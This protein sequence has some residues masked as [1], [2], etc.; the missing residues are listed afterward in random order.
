M[1][2]RTDPQL[3]TQ[4][5]GYVRGLVVVRRAVNIESPIDEVQR[6]LL[7]AQKAIRQRVDLETPAAQPNIAAWRE[8]Y[9]AFGAKPTEFPSSIEALVKR[10]RRGD[11][12]PYINTLAAICNSASLRYLVPIGGH[13]I[14]VMQA[15]GELCLGFA[16]GDE[17][18]IPFGN[19]SIEHPVP[20]EVIFTYN[21]STVLCRR[22]TWRQGELSKLQRTTTAAVI[23]VDGLPPVTRADVEVISNDLATLVGMYCGNAPTEVKMLSEEQIEVEL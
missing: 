21:T 13:A 23:N 4:Y 5:P 16:R 8:A 10:V 11:E 2:Y 14:D 1:I 12:V 6:M 7:G 9:R 3:F 17:E 19:N 22:W 15:D 18:F 20:G